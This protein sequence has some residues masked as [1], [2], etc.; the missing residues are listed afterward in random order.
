[1]DSRCRERHLPGASRFRIDIRRALWW[2]RVVKAKAE[3]Q[4]LVLRR[5]SMKDRRQTFR[6]ATETDT[7]ETGGT[8]STAVVTLGRLLA[9]ER[10]SSR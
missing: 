5:D 8:P 4:R 9:I 10:P 7:S 2:A 6:A 3:S 1:M